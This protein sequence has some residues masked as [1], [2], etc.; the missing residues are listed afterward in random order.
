MQTRKETE[1]KERYPSPMLQ[2]SDNAIPKFRDCR[3]FSW[4]IISEQYKSLLLYI[5]L[6]NFH[7]RAVF[8]QDFIGAALA[9]KGAGAPARQKKRWYWGTLSGV[10]SSYNCSSTHIIIMPHTPNPE[11]LFWKTSRGKIEY[12]PAKYHVKTW[13]WAISGQIEVQISSRPLIVWKT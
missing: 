5:F 11:I 1:R 10:L 13:I 8:L 2:T 4:F 3:N 9:R 12:F 7:L 6:E